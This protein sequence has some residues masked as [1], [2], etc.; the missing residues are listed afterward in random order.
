VI[1]Q[2]AGLNVD[3]LKQLLALMLPLKLG[4]PGLFRDDLQFV[5]GCVAF[6]LES[7]GIAV[8]IA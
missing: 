6:L 2:I 3:G 1:E 5:L 7:V 8:R 4:N